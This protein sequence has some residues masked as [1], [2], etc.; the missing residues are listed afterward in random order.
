VSKNIEP[1]ILAGAELKYSEFFEVEQLPCVSVQHLYDV[2]TAII[3]YVDNVMG[4]RRNPVVVVEG[5]RYLRTSPNRM[6]NFRNVIKVWVELQRWSAEPVLNMRRRIREL[7]GFYSYRLTLAL[8]YLMLYIAETDLNY[9]RRNNPPSIASRL[10]PGPGVLFHPIKVIYHIEYETPKAPFEA[11]MEVTLTAPILVFNEQNDS[12]CLDT[13]KLNRLIDNFLDQL[14]N[15]YSAAS[16]TTGNLIDI[17]NS[18]KEVVGYEWLKSHAWWG[19]EYSIILRWLMMAVEKL[20]LY[21]GGP[22]YQYYAWAVRN[23]YPHDDE[24]FGVWPTTDFSRDPYDYPHAMPELGIFV[25]FEDSAVAKSS[26]FRRLL[27][28]ATDYYQ[29]LREKGS[30]I[31]EE[32]VKRFVGG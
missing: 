25:G 20:N 28:E 31:L 30:K 19:F 5:T 7:L 15:N 6:N 4:I 18:R 32:T 10:P 23:P 11:Q 29:K 1:G 24:I 8:R 9:M 12:V 26:G 2:F 16:E 27:E 13:N 22:A 21:G 3:D 14:Y 17:L